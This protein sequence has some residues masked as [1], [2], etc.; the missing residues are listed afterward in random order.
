M[1]D[2]GEP[3]PWDTQLPNFLDRFGKREMR[4]MFFMPQRVENDLF[5]APDLFAFGLVDAAGVGDIGEVA[6]TKT[7]DGH[8]HM[9]DLDRDHRDIADGERVLVDA[10]E[11]EIGNAGIL[12]VGE[13]IG[14]FPYDGLL[15]HLVGKEV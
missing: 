2:M 7:E 10:D 6:K 4:K 9:P 5:A 11:A 3:G 15:G 14:E 12:H 13:S 8:L 1:A